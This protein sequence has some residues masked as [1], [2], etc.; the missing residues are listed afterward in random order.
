MAAG[1]H[2]GRR[3]PKW[4]PRMAARPK[5]LHGQKIAAAEGPGPLIPAHWSYVR[6]SPELGL[7][8]GKRMA[9]SALDLAPTDLTADGNVLL[10]QLLKFGEGETDPGRLYREQE[11]QNQLRELFQTTSDD[12]AHDGS[13]PYKPM[14]RGSL[15][16]L[17]E[18]GSPMPPGMKE[19]IL[20][21]LR[22]MLRKA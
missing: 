12:I 7:G 18:P 22:E 8:S 14:D 6:I 13:T 10:R 15:K 17:S 1:G 9:G 3:R 5:W 4:L 21:E 16:K 2:F 20:L 19:K 11:K